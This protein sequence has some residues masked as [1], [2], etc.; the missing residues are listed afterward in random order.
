M[1]LE[2]PETGL[3]Y[4]AGMA[5]DPRRLL[6]LNA[7]VEEVEL[8]EFVQWPRE[9]FRRPLP[10]PLAE[11]LE[12]FAVESAPAAMRRQLD[13]AALAEAIAARFRGQRVTW[14][15]VLRSLVATD[16]LPDDPSRALR[17]LRRSGRALCRSLR[18]LAVQ[19]DFPQEPVVTRPRRTQP[20]SL[21]PTFR[22]GD[23]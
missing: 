19:I 9:R 3:L 15:E 1:Q 20:P 4:L 12:L 13:K 16:V 23:G 21:F 22:A 2:L 14:G 7:T 17:V 6:A 5:A 8:D 11:P 10:S 18:E